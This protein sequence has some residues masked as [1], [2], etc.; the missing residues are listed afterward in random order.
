M[1]EKQGDQMEMFTMDISEVTEMSNIEWKWVLHDI[2]MYQK[3]LS[4]S[5]M[6]ILF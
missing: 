5:I 1:N 6:Y 2:S 4:L 3:Q